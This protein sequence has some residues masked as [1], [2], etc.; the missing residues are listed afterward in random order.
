MS[1]VIPSPEFNEQV[2]SAVRAELRRQ[3]GGNS[4]LEQSF[5]KTPFIRRS[6][7][8]TEELPASA[9]SNDPFSLLSS[10][11]VEVFRPTSN[12]GLVSL[13]EFITVYNR[14]TDREGC[15]GTYVEFE[16]RQGK[17]L[18]VELC[19]DEECSEEQSA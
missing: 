11:E 16:F 8:L 18:V 17:W 3:R 13:N 1:G 2:K 5:A 19:T 9:N 15:A 10:A 4:E 6:G 14:Y 7:Y 12:G